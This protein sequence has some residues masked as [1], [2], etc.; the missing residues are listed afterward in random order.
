MNLLW[1]SQDTG[2]YE[3]SLQRYEK[4]FVK[5]LSKTRSYCLNS[6]GCIYDYL[7]Q[8]DLALECCK[9]PTN[10][11][12]ISYESHIQGIEQHTHTHVY[13]ITII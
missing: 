7:K 6:I 10:E 1:V 2:L 9:I 8:Y 13:M 12:V 5:V 3:F 4:S 11:K